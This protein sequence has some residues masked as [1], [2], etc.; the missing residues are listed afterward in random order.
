MVGPSSGG[1]PP[2]AFGDQ[3]AYVDAGNLHNYR[4]TTPYLEWVQQV[5]MA[6]LAPETGSRPVWTTECG[7]QTATNNPTYGFHPVPEDVQALYLLRTLLVHYLA[8]IQRTYIY[9]FVETFNDPGLTQPNSHFGI[10]R[11]DYSLKPAYTAIKNLIGLL[12]PVRGPSCLRPQTV[13]VSGHTDWSDPNYTDYLYRLVLQR[14][15]GGYAVIVWRTV[16]SYNRES[17]TRLAPANE[18]ITVNMPWL[19][20]AATIND[21]IAGASLPLTVAGGAATFSLGERPLVVIT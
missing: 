5:C 6:G 11:N 19:P 13:T 17:A 10:V 14:A 7:F 15:D 8:G 2:S 21:P 12:G 3:S 20:A 4:D 16:S 18:T 9:E 1:A